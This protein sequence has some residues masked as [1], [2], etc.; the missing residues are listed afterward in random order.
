M[1]PSP[2]PPAFLEAV[3]LLPGCTVCGFCE[4]VAPEVFSV[5]EDGCRLKPGARGLWDRFLD[6]VLSAERACPA[7]A[8]RC[9]TAPGG[10]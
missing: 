2:V 4:A 5:A 7:G 9:R 3:E 8:I 10:P 1:T 6:D